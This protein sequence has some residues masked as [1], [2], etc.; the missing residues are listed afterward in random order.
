MQSFD[1]FEAATVASIGSGYGGFLIPFLHGFPNL[2]AMVFESAP[3]VEGAEPMFQALGLQ[4]QVTFVAGDILKDIPVEAEIYFL[5]GVLQ[6]HD[7]AHAHT[8]LTNCR[9]ALP[10]G[11]R[12][13]VYERL[14]PERSEDDPAAIMLDLHMMVITGGRTRSLAEFGAL[15][16]EAGLAVSRVTPTTSGLSVI[17]ARKK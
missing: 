11:A 15:L 14:M 12:L 1:A 4:H 6:Q 8:I 17:E 5:K 9:K 10:D 16:D 3:T 7:D 2:K 13:I